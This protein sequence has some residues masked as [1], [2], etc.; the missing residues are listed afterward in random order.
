MISDILI[1]VLSNIGLI[2]VTIFILNGITKNFI[3][4]YIKV[5]ASRGKLLMVQVRHPIMDYFVIGKVIGDKLLFR[6]R[7]TK[8]GQEKPVVFRS[9][10]VF[11]LLGINFVKIDE[12]KS[13]YV[14]PDMNIVS[15]Y[16]HN[17]ISNWLVRALTEPKSK[18]QKQLMHI[19]IVISVVILL[20]VIVSVFNIFTLINN[21]KTIITL[22]NNMNQAGVI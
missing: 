3:F 7:T 17:K 4:K 6:D 1:Q 15:G 14:M 5:W 18:E 19:I 13:L 20:I 16:D 11:R 12:E 2:L 10:S 21:S 8:K 9:G 22:I